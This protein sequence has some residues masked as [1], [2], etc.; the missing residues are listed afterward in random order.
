MWLGR[1]RWQER[2][3]K[4]AALGW[5]LA[6]FVPLEILMFLAEKG[7]FSPGVTFFLLSDYVPPFLP[8]MLSCGSAAVLIIVGCLWIGER[9]AEK[10]WVYAL[11]ATGRMTLRNGQIIT[12]KFDMLSFHPDDPSF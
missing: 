9:F 3:V 1:L 11:A 12:C 5:S 8:F 7:C 6:V 10:K 2:A 4:I